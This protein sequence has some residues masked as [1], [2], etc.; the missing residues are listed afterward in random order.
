M[1]RFPDFVDLDNL[2]STTEVLFD[3]IDD[4][5]SFFQISVWC[6]STPATGSVSVTMKSYENGP[7]Q[8]LIVGGSAVVIDLTAGPSVV[9]VNAMYMRELKFTQA[10]LEVGKKWNVHVRQATTA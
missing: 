10:S 3:T 6:D 4:D 9:V 7:F 8:D 2:H 5:A 1:Y